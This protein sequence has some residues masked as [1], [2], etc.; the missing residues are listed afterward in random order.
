MARWCEVK[1]ECFA[2]FVLLIILL[3]VHGCLLF[4]SCPDTSARDAP[5]QPGARVSANN[6]VSFIYIVGV[7]GVGHHGITPAIV[8]IAKSC[9]MYVMSQNADLRRAMVLNVATPYLYA[10]QRI[11]DRPY[12]N[13]WNNK[14]AIIEDSSFPTGNCSRVSSP[15]EK[16]GLHLYDLVRLHHR[17]RSAYNINLKY[18]YL[19]R[20]FYRTVASHPEF[21]GTFQRHAQ[22]L[23]DFIGYLGTEYA[24]INA[25]ERGLWRQV[26]YEWFTEMKNCTQLVSAII[27]FVGWDGCDIEEACANL[28][29]VIRQ[30]T[31]K[32]VN[33]TDKAFADAFDVKLPIPYLEYRP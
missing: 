1:F 6:N 15:V 3:W 24:A 18:L 23:S 9:K 28:R 22:V 19:N 32:E 14:I 13:K 29:N 5:R 10:L 16:K 12:H 30:P 25:A 2:A 31:V 20:D 27:G 11:R 26:S 21:D 17:T 8:E 33:A 7:E 4:D